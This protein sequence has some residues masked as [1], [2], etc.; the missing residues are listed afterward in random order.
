[1]RASH[2]SGVA[3]DEGRDHAHDGQGQRRHGGT[4]AFLHPNDIRPLSV[5]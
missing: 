1:V 2:E 5:R 3:S 4:R